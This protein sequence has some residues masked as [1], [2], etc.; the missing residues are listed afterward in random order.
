MA[1]STSV[2]ILTFFCALLGLASLSF[3]QAAPAKIDKHYYNYSEW[4]KGLFA[5]AVTV[6]GFGNGKL[7]YLG[8]IGAEDEHGK[9]GA[10]RSPKNF[11]GQCKYTFEKIGRVLGYNG[12]SLKDITKMTSYLTS[13]RNIGAYIACRNKAFK[14]ADAKLPAETLLIINRLAWPPMKLE[15][16]V[17]AITAK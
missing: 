11:D 4:T 13:A 8:G 1:K 9:A 15:V 10:I 6:T 2:A 14:A 5:E 12:A 17:D 3:G 16:D 7:I